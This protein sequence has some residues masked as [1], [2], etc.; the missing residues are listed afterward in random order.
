MPSRKNI[1]E[2][3]AKASI[4]RSLREFGLDVSQTGGPHATFYNKILTL[5]LDLTRLK[6]S[7]ST[8]LVGEPL[9]DDR[10]K[11]IEHVFM[12][13]L[14]DFVRA[15][16]ECTI[17]YVSDSLKQHLRQCDE[18]DRDRILYTAPYYFRNDGTERKTKRQFWRFDASILDPIQRFS[19]SENEAA[20]VSRASSA[21]EDFMD[22]G[23]MEGHAF[24]ALVV[25]WAGHHVSCYCCKVEKSLQWSGGSETSWRDMFCHRCQSCYEIK[26]KANKEAIDKIVG[27]DGLYGGSYA[28][29]CQE[30][31]GRITSCL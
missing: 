23:C 16:D 1:S 5:V 12:A 7:A 11:A 17:R 9:P 21:F 3:D 26:S 24:E 28:R 30:Q 18:D 13:N 14:E 15:S 4:T 10:I 25:S 31:R 20:T 6:G 19:I 22:E 29:W 8:E 2:R 27:Y